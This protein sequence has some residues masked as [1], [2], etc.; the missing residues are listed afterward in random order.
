MILFVVLARLIV[1]F[2]VGLDCFVSRRT[3]LCCF[4]S[5]LVVLFHVGLDC[6]V[7]L[8]TFPFGFV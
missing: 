1:L 6:F 2:H 5:D 4:T 7:S 3:L 8:R